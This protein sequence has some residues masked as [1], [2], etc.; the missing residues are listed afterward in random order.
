[1]EEERIDPT[2]EETEAQQA[3]ETGEKENLS[4]AQ[5]QSLAQALAAELAAREPTPE[6]IAAEEARRREEAMRAAKLRRKRRRRKGFRDLIIRTVFMAAIIYVLFFHL[7]GIIKMPTADMYPRLDEG[8]LI[9]FFRMEKN[10]RAQD[11]IVVQKDV[12][13]MQEAMAANEAASFEK[14]DEGEPEQAA[15]AQNAAAQE[16]PQPDSLLGRIGRKARQLWNKALEKLGFR[17]PEGKQVFVLRVVATAGD[18]V[19]ITDE[20]RLLINNNAVIESNIFY[21]TSEYVGFI[22]Y[23]LTL[24]AGECFVLAD[25]RDNGGADSRFFGVVNE[26]EILGTVF[27]IVRRNNL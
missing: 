17:V 19:E 20:G 27:T 4:D 7:V 12:T 18:T 25:R 1:M 15:L 9:L 14:E 2:P 24:H 16:E 5:I 21:H 10:V 26:D 22:K 3:E 8:D 13:A 11:I 23:P 6:E